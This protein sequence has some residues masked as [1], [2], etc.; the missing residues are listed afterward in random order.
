MTRHSLFIPA[1]LFSLSVYGQA[2]GLS[3]QECI[4]LSRANNPDV[5]NAGLDARAAKAQKQ[6]TMGLWFPTVAFSAYGFHALNPLVRIGIEDVL[7]SGDGANNLRYYLETMAGLNGINTEW[8]TLGKGYLAGLTLS[9]P[10]FAGGRIANGNALA[11]LGVKAAEVKKNI[12]VRDNDDAVIRKYWLV[13]SLNEKMSALRQALELLHSLEKDAVNASEA[14]VVT[15]NDVLK[16]KLKAKELESQM[17]QLRSG[18]RLA[19]MD[20]L[21]TVGYEYKVMK[22]DSVK[23][24]DGFGELYAPEHY[25]MDGAGASRSR[26]ESELLAMSVEAKKLEKKMAVG[27]SLPQIGVGASLG[28]GQVIGNPRPNGAVFAMVKIPLSDWGKS[29]RKIQRCQYEIEKAENQKAFLDRQLQ[30]KQDKEWVDLQTAW[31]KVQLSKDAVEIAEMEERQKRDEYCV[32]MCTLS[33]LLQCQTSLQ[34]ARSAL[35]D[36]E[37]EYCNAVA[38]W[39]R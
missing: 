13:V 21:N 6:E 4:A 3:L 9:Q 23:L 29:S 17:V 35:V 19:K 33:E 7:G 14:G 10:V 15:G 12:A 31:D 18:E 32:G 20:L 34:A 24:S 22:L 26:E 28:Y 39:Q 5:V 27:E 25:Q 16:V 38:V 1:L 8:T 36:S 11:A 2:D 30:L 37:A